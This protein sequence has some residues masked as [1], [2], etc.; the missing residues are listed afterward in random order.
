MLK[1]LEICLKSKKVSFSTSVIEP[2][3]LEN[4]SVDTQFLKGFIEF[5][6]T[7]FEERLEEFRQIGI[8]QNT[9]AWV[10]LSKCAEN[11]RSIQASISIV[12]GELEFLWSFDVEY[13]ESIVVEN[14]L[15]A[16]KDYAHKKAYSYLYDHEDREKD[17][18]IYL[19][20]I[21]AL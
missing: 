15:N 13:T 9:F 10:K 6:Q 3:L 17:V 5:I 8:D 11:M 16:I 19:G 21:E 12:R 14:I 20:L 2:L 7:K 18:P 4:Q 1:N